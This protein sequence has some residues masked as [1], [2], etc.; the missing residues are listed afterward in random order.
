MNENKLI[1]VIGAYGS[2]KSEYSIN[3]AKKYRDEDHSV[4]LC[5]LDVVNPY[6]RSRDVREEFAE[7]GIDV[8]A[9]EAEYKH[10]DLPMISPRVRGMILKTD[11]T[12]ILDVGGDPTGARA[13][14]RFVAE[15][16]KRGYEMHFVV[17]TN[18]PFTSNNIE[19]QQMLEM[20][21]SVSTLKVTEIVCNTNL[22]EYTDKDVVA[23]GVGIITEVAEELNLIFDKYLVLDKFEDI[24]PDNLGNK[25]RVIDRK[26]VM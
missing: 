16:K 15:I 23:K 2:G 21:E 1:I 5:D 4:A 10:A 7:L 6:F 12:V 9:P 19:I 3:L 24:V 25:K 17:N 26:S 8:V 22:M 18:R 11:K 14:G 13:L 20:I